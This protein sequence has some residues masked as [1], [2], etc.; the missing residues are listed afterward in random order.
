[1][2]EVGWFGVDFDGTLAHYDSWQ[3]W[4]KLGAPIPRMVERVRGWLAEGRSVKIFTAR[5]QYGE[6][7]IGYIK[8]WCKEHIG[9]ELEVTNVKD[10]HMVVLYD[11]R[12]VGVV[13]NTGE[14][15]NDAIASLVRP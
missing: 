6:P 4:E 11:D 13:T 12:A 14:L 5:A 8:A 9:R 3:G 1:M 2:G 15:V 10:Q 7:Q